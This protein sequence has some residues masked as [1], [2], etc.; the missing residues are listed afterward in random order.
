MSEEWIAFT[1]SVILAT[2]TIGV[3]EVF[4]KNKDLFRNIIRQYIQENGEKQQR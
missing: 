1:N 2:E 3:R 4:L